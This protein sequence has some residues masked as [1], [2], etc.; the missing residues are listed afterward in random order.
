MAGVTCSTIRCKAERARVDTFTI[1]SEINGPS[2]DRAS[3]SNEADLSPAKI[4]RALTG[5]LTATTEL[6]YMLE[7]IKKNSFKM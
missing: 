6:K 3:T 2:A 7:K 5:G 4:G 1:E